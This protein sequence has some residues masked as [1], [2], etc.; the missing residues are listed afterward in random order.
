MAALAA[1]QAIDAAGIAA[2]AV[3]RG[4]NGPAIGAAV[5]EARVNAI[6]TAI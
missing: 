5:S 4:L 6:A 3:E 2:R 1:A